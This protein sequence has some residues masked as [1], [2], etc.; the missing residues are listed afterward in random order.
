MFPFSALFSVQ[1]T[2]VHTDTKRQVETEWWQALPDLDLL[3]N[4][5]WMLLPLTNI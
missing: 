3:L 4:C 5:P 1:E 2:N